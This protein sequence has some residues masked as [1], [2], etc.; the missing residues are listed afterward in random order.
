[1]S[2]LRQPCFCLCV[3]VSVFACI[4]VFHSLCY[5]LLYFSNHSFKF[6][7]EELYSYP[8][9][10]ISYCADDKRDKKLF[11]FIAK[12]S[13]QQHHNCYVFE[14]EKMVN[15]IMVQIKCS[16]TIVRQTIHCVYVY[17]HRANSEKS[18]ILRGSA[19]SQY[20]V[21]FIAMSKISLNPFTLEISPVVLLTVCHTILTVLV[22]RIW[23]WINQYTLN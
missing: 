14:C 22:Q 13:G 16:F 20:S 4:S 1:M 9:H 12:D 23:Y 8:L 18:P 15:K 11:A 10:R 7:Q 3:F 19:S 6:L 2:R 5:Y 17:K 21:S